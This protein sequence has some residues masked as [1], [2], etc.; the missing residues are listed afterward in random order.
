MSTQERRDCD[1]DNWMGYWQ[2][3]KNKIIYAIV[4]WDTFFPICLWQIWCT[5]NSNVFNNATD[6]V[7]FKEVMGRSA[8]FVALVHNRG[9]PPRTS[10]QTSFMLSGR[11]QKQATLN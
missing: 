2:K 9:S 7:N 4:M 6:Q 11:R 8:E 3:Y 1:I 5:R 10:M